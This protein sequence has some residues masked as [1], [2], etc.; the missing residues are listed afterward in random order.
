MGDG[1]Y[2]WG[3]SGN[4]QIGLGDPT[5]PANHDGCINFCRLTPSRVIDTSDAPLSGVSAIE[6]AY[7]GVC[8]RMTDHTLRCWGFE[9]GQVA[10]E[11]TIG[12]AMIEIAAMTTCSS[13]SV[14]MAIRYLQRDGTL[15]DRTRTIDPVCVAP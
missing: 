15:H 1:V 3:S 5:L 11:P 8:A 6:V 7:Q 14:P 9:L 4:G 2:C 13:S 10:T 12:G